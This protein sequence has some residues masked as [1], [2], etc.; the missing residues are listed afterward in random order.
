MESVVTHEIILREKSTSF[1]IIVIC[2]VRNGQS[3][4][5]AKSKL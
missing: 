3:Q 4:D 5:D 2:L 1:F